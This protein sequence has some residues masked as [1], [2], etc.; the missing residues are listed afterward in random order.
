[1]PA[2]S[3][4]DDL[5]HLVSKV[6]DCCRGVP[7]DRLLLLGAGGGEPRR[8]VD[9]SVQVEQLIEGVE[10]SRISRR[11]PLED[12]RPTRIHGLSLA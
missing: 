10:L 4:D 6:G 11:E 9:D 5:P 7:P 12:D 1:M 3:V 2:A 8:S